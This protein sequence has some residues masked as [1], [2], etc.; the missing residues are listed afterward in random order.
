MKLTKEQIKTLEDTFNYAVN[1]LED[2]EETSFM[3]VMNDDGAFEKF[4]AEKKIKEITELFDV[5]R[6]NI[7]VEND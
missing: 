2:S 3:F 7:E 5:L 6:K 1:A 4:D